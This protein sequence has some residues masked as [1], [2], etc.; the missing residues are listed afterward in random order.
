MKKKYTKPQ[1]YFED[2]SPSTNIAADCESI[3]GNASKGTCA[4]IGTG[5]IAIFDGNVGGGKVCAFTPA[6]LEQE[7]DKWDGF[8]YHVPTEYNNL[9]N[10]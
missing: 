1:I 6:D 4:V 7:A 10:S 3:V 9:F 5:G 2:F 8:C